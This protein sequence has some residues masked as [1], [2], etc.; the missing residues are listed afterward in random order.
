MPQGGDTSSHAAIVIARQREQTIISLYARGARVSQIA[1]QLSLPDPTVRSALK[2]ALYRLPKAD[3]VALRKLQAERIQDMRLKVWGEISGRQDEN[4][5]TIPSEIPITQL[6]DRAL[7]IERH[8]AVLFGLDAPAK[9]H[10][11]VDD[12]GAGGHL[13][14]DEELDAGLARLTEE[15][16]D[17]FMRLLAK[18]RGYWIEPEPLSVET[19]ASVVPIASKIE[20]T[21]T[22]P[23]TELHPLQTEGCD[24]TQARQVIRGGSAKPPEIREAPATPIS[25]LGFQPC[26]KC[27]RSPRPDEEAIYNNRVPVWHRHCRPAAG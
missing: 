6:I 21:K 18:I 4:G 23:G 1:R 22:L 12:A 19:T 24:A 14:T 7:K 5:R 9:A 27:G 20:P 11:A 26:P 25:S 3:V 13:M 16:K 17:E 2:R 15:E 10:V 8:E